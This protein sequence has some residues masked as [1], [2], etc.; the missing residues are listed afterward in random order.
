MR[1]AAHWVNLVFCDLPVPRCTSSCHG[2]YFQAGADWG[3]PC[4]CAG[5]FTSSCA[6]TRPL[7]IIPLLHGQ[8]APAACQWNC[9]RLLDQYFASCVSPS[10]KGLRSVYW[11][12]P[13]CWTFFCLHLLWPSEAYP[14]DFVGSFFVLKLPL[15][16]HIIS[17]LNTAASTDQPVL[18]LLLCVPV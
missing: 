2:G 5:P 7:R 1:Q 9:A 11:S 3:Y 13:C 16:A 6:S 4:S 18:L 14:C 10:C 17:S 15:K 8:Q 12:R